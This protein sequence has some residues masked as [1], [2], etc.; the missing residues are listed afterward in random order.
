MGEGAFKFDLTVNSGVAASCCQKSL[1]CYA[2]SHCELV[3]Q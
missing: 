3:T 2:Q 1:K